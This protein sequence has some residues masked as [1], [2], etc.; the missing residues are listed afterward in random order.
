[1]HSSPEAF[2]S[3]LEFQDPTVLLRSG[4]LKDFNAKLSSC[5]TLTARLQLISEQVIGRVCFSS[6]LGLE[7]QAIFAALAEA[8]LPCD[9]FT[10]DTGRHFPETLEILS[11]TEARYRRRIRVV[12]P[13]AEEVEH[14]VT[15]DGIL[16]FRHSLENRKAC[17]AIRKVH[18]LKRV[19]KGAAGWVTG[20]RRAQSHNRSDVPFANWDEENQIIKLNPIADWSLETLSAFIEENS[21]PINALHTKGFPSIGCQPCTRAI[22]PGE[23]I[24]AGRWWWEQEE[25]KECGLHAPSEHRKS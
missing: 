8:N 17:C 6:S 24:R 15:R 23:D 16:G 18:P 2:K 21:V 19:L 1:M 22:R 11:V 9:V 5:P 14:L 10:I 12:F 4:N 13:E 20:L 25:G 7:D 3:T